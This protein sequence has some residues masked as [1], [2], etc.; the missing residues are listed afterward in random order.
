MDRELEIEKLKGATKPA[1]VLWLLGYCLIVYL[2]IHY[3]WCAS[4]LASA[5]RSCD[6]FSL[7]GR[8]LFGWVLKTIQNRGQRIMEVTYRGRIY[9]SV[10]SEHCR[11][12][13]GRRCHRHRQP[14]I[15]TISINHQRPTRRRKSTVAINTC[16][17]K[18]LICRFFCPHCR[19]GI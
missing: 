13:V 1:N 8:L 17:F 7:V 19:C 3:G 6:H 2:I 15:S 9:G 14:H 18:S 10:V 11:S 5:H 4:A 12:A 16:L